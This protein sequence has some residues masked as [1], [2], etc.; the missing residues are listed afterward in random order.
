MDRAGLWTG[1]YG[2]TAESVTAE[3]DTV[4]IR[5]DGGLA[6][7]LEDLLQATRI[8]PEHVYGKVGDITK[9]IDKEPVSSGPFVVEAYNGRRLTLV[10][11][12]DYW[13]ADKIKVQ[14]ISQEG[15]YDP[16]SA[17]LKLRTGALDIYT[18]DIPNPV[19]SVR[20]AGVTDFLYSPAGT[21]VLAPNNEK[22][23][24]NDVGFREALAYAINKEQVSRNASFGVMKQGSQ[25][26][27]K[28]PIQEDALPAEYRDD[29]GYVPYDPDKAEQLLDAAGYTKGKDGFRTAKDGKP[30]QLTFS[31]QA[32]FIDYLAIADVV[33]RNLNDIGVRTKQIVTDPPAVDAAR[34]T[35]TFDL[36]IDYVGG[37]CSRAKDLG[38]HLSTANIPKEEDTAVNLNTE[39]FSDPAVDAVVDKYLAATDPKAQQQY[40]DQVIDVYTKRFPVIALMY[41][42]QRF[43]YNTPAASGWPTLSADS[44]PTDQLLVVMTHLRPREG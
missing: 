38:G 6:A 29:K 5:T 42:P 21:T 9:Y 20:R 26:M 34:K 1:A 36:A 33:T 4:V 7:K 12:E 28:L 31:V 39:R 8:L 23:P 13:Q 41:A 37:T 15:T 44:Y 16:N 10:R 2:S 35:G 32:G 11:N 14:Q 18:G 24:M 40:L 25:T 22:A 17:A 43:I 3:G 30:M 27:L 19:A